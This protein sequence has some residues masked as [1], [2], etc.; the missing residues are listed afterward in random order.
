MLYIDI[1]GL[2]HINRQ[3]GFE[4]G[5]RLIIEFSKILSRQFGNHRICRFNGDHFAAVTDEDRVEMDLQTILLECDTLFDGNKLPIRVGVY[6]NSLDTVDVNIACDRAKFAC[7]KA[8]GELGSSITYYN[9][10]MLKTVET[11]HHIVHNLDRALDEGWIKVYYQ[12]II[13]AAEGKICDEEALARW[14]DP[15]LGFLSPGVFIPAL[16]EAKL[17]YKLDLYVVDRVLE[18]IKQQIE[19]GIYLV[20][21][22]INLSRMDFESC[23]VVEEIRSR[24]DNAGI[25]R[26]MITVE[27]TE[28]VIGSN[29]D[30]MKEQILRFQELG[31]PVWMDDFGSGYS[32]LD[33]LRHIHF[34]LIKFDMR[35][36]D[37]FDEGDENKIILTELMNMAIGLG[38]DTVCEGV[39]TAEQVE[40]LKEIGCTRIQGYYYGKPIPFEEVV[41]KVKS[42]SYLEYENPEESEYYT[43]IGHINL[44]DITSLASENDE[45]DESLSQYFNTLPMS[46]MEVNGMKVRFNRCNRSYRDFMTRYMGVEYSTEEIDCTNLDPQLGSNFLTTVLQC[47]RDGNRTILDERVGEKTVTHTLIRRIAVNPVTGVVAI[48]VAVLAVITEGETTGTSYSQMAKAMVPDYVELYY[49]S[50]D[51]EEYIK[52]S[53]NPEHEFLGTELRGNNFFANSKKDALTRLYVDDQEAFISVFTKQ[54]VVDTMDAEGKFKITYRLMMDDKPTYVDLKAV[55]IPGD[56]SHII[57]GINNVDAQM[58]QNEELSRIQAERTV[59]SRISALTQDIICIYIVDPS[60]GHY[61]EYRSSNDYA[62]LGAP[63]QGE[64]FFAESLRESERLIYSYDMNII[65]TN[66]TCD[67]IMFQVKAHGF[68][69]F[70]YRLL[71]NG[72]PHY[73]SLKAVLVEE[74][75][76]PVLVIGIY[77]IDEQVKHEQDLERGLSSAYIE[78]LYRED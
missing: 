16:E 24:V 35:F 50:L 63:T 29:F 31:F 23:D 22:S 61:V 64:D 77:D 12:P 19:A 48:A 59:Y 4:K 56:P 13:R 39:E 70:R 68:Y 26:S 75:D 30:F 45:N 20:P 15:E 41:S 66:L 42:G 57:V 32:S 14:I 54:N 18:K 51:T 55:R 78:S 25:E 46:I 27:I 71:L 69:S 1:I 21:Q 65:R 52:Y 44:Y 33:V 37:N 67:N 76:E 74:R 28:S 5:D 36:M 58:R 43:S 10:A 47:S 2:R 53:P 60:T 73:V 17:I 6:P 72:K 49:V 62:V 7:D 9:A 3:Y 11:Q 34:D 8:K 38:T 40:F